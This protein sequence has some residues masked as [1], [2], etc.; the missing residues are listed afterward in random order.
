MKDLVEGI[1]RKYA[2]KNAKEYGKAEIPAVIGKVIA[3]IPN[4]KAEIAQLMPTIKKVVDQVNSLSY[5]QIEQELAKY[6]FEER[7]IEKRKV[8]LPPPTDNVVTRFAPEPSG[9]LHLGHAKAVFLAHEAAKEYRGK[10]YLRF[11]DT[12]PELAKQEYVDAIKRDLNWLGVGWDAEESTSDF[13]ELFYDY[14]LELI[15]KGRAYVCDCTPELVKLNRRERKECS[16]R[17]KVI[18]P[19]VSEFERMVDEG[20]EEGKAI[21]RFIGNMKSHNT[22]MRDPTL[23]RIV[24]KEHFRHGD[25]YVMWPTYDLAAPILDSVRGITH[26]M[27]SKEYELRDELYFDILD[28]LGLRKPQIVSFSRLEIKNN[29]TSK[30]VLRDLVQKK[31][32]DG[33]DD[34]R[35]L[36]IQGLRRRGFLPN[37]IKEFALSFGIGKSESKEA[38]LEPILVESRKQFDPTAKRLYF[39]KDPIVIEIRDLKKNASVPFHPDKD[40][41]SRDFEVDGKVFVDKD[42]VEVGETVR[43]KD[44]CSVRIEKR[45]KGSAQ[46][47]VVET[48]EMPDK[49]IQWVPFDKFARAEV[50]KPGDLLDG[51]KINKKNL[52]KFE[53]YVE[54]SAEELKEN[55]IVQFIRFGFVKL[56]RKEDGKLTFIFTA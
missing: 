48:D 50:L 17:N 53:G 6:S 12:N 43:L 24:K 14:A 15:K 2:L 28:I 42:D 41:G 8:R 40:L 56:D 37:T 47:S 26:A 49:R 55:E 34:P 36:T 33:W 1:V 38:T 9:Y 16:C 46:A 3:E 4:A 52:V 51:D 31:L 7:K 13:M 30:R 5:E 32:V 39:V 29:P 20:Y 18:K 10:F 27:R 11:D 35:L 22:V 44:L 19:N 45:D 54:K 23:M 21:L 25:K